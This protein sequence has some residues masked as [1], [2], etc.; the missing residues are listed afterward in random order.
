MLLIFLVNLF[1]DDAFFR[2][3]HNNCAYAVLTK[4]EFVAPVSKY[5]FGNDST[6]RAVRI[7]LCNYFCRKENKQ[8][9][10]YGCVFHLFV[11]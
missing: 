10:Q 5:V 1:Q 2:L 4:R 8:R 11:D 3:A 9:K 6:S 7:F